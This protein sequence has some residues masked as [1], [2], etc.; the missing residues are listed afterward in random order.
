VTGWKTLIPCPKQEDAIV[1]Y[2]R[3][4]RPVYLARVEDDLG[5]LAA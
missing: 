3:S 2:L 5:R 4:P 1:A